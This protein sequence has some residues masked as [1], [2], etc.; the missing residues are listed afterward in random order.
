MRVVLKYSLW[1]CG[2]IV[3]LVLLLAGV[4]L[5][6]QYQQQP[7]MWNDPVFDTVPPVFENLQHETKVLSFSKTN[8]F[9]HHEAIPAANSL[10][11]DIANQHDWSLATTENTA[12]FNEQQLSQFDVIVFNNATNPHY[13]VQQ[14]QALQ[15]FIEN[16]GGFVGIHAAGDGSHDDWKWYT[17]KVIRAEFTMHPIW[18]QLQMATLNVE[19]SHPVATGLAAQWQTT[20]EWYSFKES[21]RS[22]G[23]DVLLTIDEKTYDPNQWP[24]GNDHPLVWAHRL[25]QGRIVYSALGHTADSYQDS[26]HRQ[27]LLQAIIWAGSIK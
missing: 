27:L 17:E 9:R 26:H 2:I 11:S 5:W 10:L 6:Q 7:Q 4:F 8:D 18:P 3:L 1:V 21:V 19:N 23:S 24:M 20:D 15:H 14:K 25:K 22:K 12:V 13:T 16:G